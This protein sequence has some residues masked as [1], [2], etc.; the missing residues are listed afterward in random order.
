MQLQ[1][2]KTISA[3]ANS[4]TNELINSRLDSGPAERWRFSTTNTGQRVMLIAMNMN[5]TVT[6]GNKFILS[7]VRCLSMHGS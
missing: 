3:H 6:I 7:I 2:C 4:L 5:G 1:R